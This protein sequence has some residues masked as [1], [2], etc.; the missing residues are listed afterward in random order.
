MNPELC[1]RCRLKFSLLNCENCQESFCSECDSYIHS[2]LSKKDHIRKMIYSKPTHETISKLNLNFNQKELSYS[3]KISQKQISQN[4]TS[5]IPAKTNHFSHRSNNLTYDINNINAQNNNLS[6]FDQDNI[7][8]K[9]HN[10]VIIPQ[11]LS[12][13]SNRNKNRNIEENMN[14]FNEIHE[15]NTLNRNVTGFYMNEIK[16]IYQY[17]KNELI[18][19]INQ[20][21]KELV[22]TKTNLGEHID[23]LNNYIIQLQNNHKDQIAELTLKN[24]DDLKSHSLNQDTR[25]KELESE[26]SIEKEKNEKLQKKIEEYE[27]IIKNNKYN[28]EKLSDEKIYIDNAKKTSEDRLKQKIENIENNY[29]NEINKIKNNYETEIKR[30]KNELDLSKMDYLKMTEN[31]K[32]NL[33][34]M[35]TERTKEKSYYD[36]VI[37]KLKEDIANK[38]NE[39]EKLLFLTKNLQQ[40]NE[41]LNEKVIKMNDEINQKEKEQK[42]ML[43]SINKIQK[44]KNEI[45]RT[46]S[47]LNSVIYGRFKKREKSKSKEY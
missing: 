9:G 19:K 46:N 38:S 14:D 3:P 47:K 10:S 16:N 28:I 17:E 23:Y 11:K 1:D 34:K 40:S 27:E 41:D 12:F 5:Q 32:E 7:L 15:N 26:L 33:N 45:I 24:S 8:Q 35:I 25:I 36:N 37:N 20:L 42:E 18:I 21:S 4:N 44:E 30:I 39:N 2:I 31:S 29:T 6:L 43:K 22:D 13:D